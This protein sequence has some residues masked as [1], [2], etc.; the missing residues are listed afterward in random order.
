VVKPWR[1]GEHEMIREG[2]V[3]FAARTMGGAGGTR[4]EFTD[5]TVE[6]SLS[7][8]NDICRRGYAKA[9]QDLVT[10]NLPSNL[11]ISKESFDAISEADIYDYIGRREA[12]LTEG[13]EF[14]QDVKKACQLLKLS[15]FKYLRP[16]GMAMHWNHLGAVNNISYGNSPQAKVSAAAAQTVSVVNTVAKDVFVSNIFGNSKHVCEGGKIGL[17]IRRAGGQS[18]ETVGHPEIVPWSDRDE[19]TPLYSVR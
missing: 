15:H 16:I 12:D 6:A 17:V 5:V 7:H 3:M 8:L 11:A 2:Q 10:G 18:A 19:T 13:D 4:E 1:G 9:V 14:T